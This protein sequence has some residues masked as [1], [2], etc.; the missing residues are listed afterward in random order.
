[1]IQR[2]DMG[3]EVGGGSELGTHVHPWQIH[4]HVWQNQYSIVKQNKVKIKKKKES[5]AIM[6][7][8]AINNC[9][10]KFFFNWL[11]PIS[12]FWPPKLS[13]VTFVLF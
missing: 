10:K 5:W 12:D 3:W 13:D 7:K 9:K 1:M 2:D 6:N 11:R 4:V 8:A